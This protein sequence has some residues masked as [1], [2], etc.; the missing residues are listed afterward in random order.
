MQS[1]SV[2]LGLEG[3]AFL[4]CTSA[5]MQIFGVECNLAVSIKSTVL[6][7]KVWIILPC[8]A[9]NV[10]CGKQVHVCTLIAMEYCNIIITLHNNL[11]DNFLDLL[12]MKLELYCK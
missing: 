7:P 5:Q 8:T 10:R 12:H 4:E 3:C 9:T 6:L 11:L 1:I 2:C